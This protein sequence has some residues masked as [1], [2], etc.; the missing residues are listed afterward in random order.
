MQAAVRRHTAFRVAYRFFSGRPLD[1]IY[2]TDCTYLRRGTRV[3]AACGHASRWAHL[4]GWRRQVWRLGGLLLSGVVATGL[5]RAP[6]LTTF[7]LVA[8]L[9]AVIAWACR[10]AYRKAFT[11]SYDR[12]VV[13][14]LA[15]ALEPY[16]SLAAADV[17]AGLVLPTA[18]RREVRVPLADHHSGTRAAQ[19]DIRRIVHQRLGGEWDTDLNLR[20]KPFY[21]RFTPTPAPPE[22]VTFDMVRDAVLATSQAKPVL[23]LGSRG[24][25]IH[26]DFDGEIAH[27]AASIGT[28]GG[29]SSFLRFLVAQFA[30]HGVGSFDVCDVKW[31]SLLGM[32]QVPG[33]RVHRTVAEI[34]QA[35]AGLRREMDARYEI[36][37]KNPSRTFP[38]RILVLE[39]QNA[40]ATLARLAWR[41]E[42]NKGNHP[43]WDDIA[44]IL[45]MGR[46]VNINVIGVYQRM[47][48]SA[49]GGGDLRDQYG[50]KLLSRFSHQAWDV[51]V[52][53]RPRGVSSAI[54][55]RAIAV[56]GGTQRQVQLP[57]VTVGE[58][59]SLALSGVPVTVT[60]PAYQQVSDASPVTVTPAEPRYTLA[61][62][63]REDWCTVSYDT[64]RQRAH[65]AR[66]AGKLSP[67]DTYTRDELVGILTTIP[68]AT[69]EGDAR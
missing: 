15:A 61:E 6:R 46:Q 57:F 29:K 54:P 51:L 4:P 45:T 50:L 22:R 66:K 43:V 56:L 39:E 41:E 25:V 53:T 27:L 60:P 23:G 44:L 18:T 10:K 36:M 9:V 19:E 3:L 2:R 31:V 52:G 24:E 8:A 14:P 7:A 1:G 13:R 47:S 28:G 20:A 49:A 30:H 58:A 63:A 69:T 26:L 33:L 32:E 68:G 5:L 40:F 11:W 16:V 64:L 48:A 38:R 21:I 55:G 42:G 65:R 35:I 37:L 12:K 62:A 17:H 34:A 67:A 59:M